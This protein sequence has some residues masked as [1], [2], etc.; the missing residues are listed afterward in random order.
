M[1]E[2]IEKFAIE[3]LMEPNGIMRSSLTP[4]GQKFPPGYFT[5]EKN[6]LTVPGYEDLDYSDFTNY[7]NSGMTMGA[8]LG[9]M[10]CK[11]RVTGARADLESARK[12]FNGITTIYE[13]SQ[14]IAPGFFCKPW[15]GRLTDETSS[16]QYIYIMT[17]LDVFYDIADS[18]ERVLI[19]EM[20]EKMVL[21]WYDHDFQYKY[22]GAP[23][24]WQKSRFP[25]FFALAW[26]YTGKTFFRDMMQKLL[27]D[28]EIMADIPFNAVLK[29]EKKLQPLN[30]EN[31]ASC[32]LS[33]IHA[34]GHSPLIEKIIRS[35]VE[36][37]I[38][39]IES[40]GFG[41]AFAVYEQGKLMPLSPENAVYREG[42][43]LGWSFFSI[44]APYHRGGVAVLTFLR[45]WQDAAKVIPDITRD[46]NFDEMLVKTTNH[47]TWF[48]DPLNV[49]PDE[50]KW[51]DGVISG[52]AVTHWLWLYWQNKLK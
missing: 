15:G 4:D 38:A 32:I 7:E 5:P 2:K 16:D 29:P 30:S 47:L 31:A 35:T 37:G 50:L 26:K 14:K 22:Y 36:Y 24:S 13:M 44:T 46:M 23:L 21:F 49:L 33:V 34:A 8:F 18:G 1:Y 11:Y 51:M 17:G 19:T 27:D 42:K 6:H 9:A 41:R 28:R 20:I 52:D 3:K 48:E 40:D 10:S 45:A 39:G 25:S 43:Y 12:V